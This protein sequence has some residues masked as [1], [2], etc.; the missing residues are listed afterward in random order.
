MDFQAWMKK[1]DEH[2]TRLSSLDSRCIADWC[3]YDAF[4]GGDTPEEAAEQ[5]L[6]ADGFPEELID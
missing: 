5:A 6:L 4:E 3:Y 1:V 2:M